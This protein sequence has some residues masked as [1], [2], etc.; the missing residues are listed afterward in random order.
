M[1]KMAVT[2]TE[3]LMVRALSLKNDLTRFTQ[4]VNLTLKSLDY[5]RYQSEMLHEHTV[6]LSP[7][8]CDRAF[9]E[10][11]PKLRKVST[12]VR[13]QDS[14]KEQWSSFRLSK[15]YSGN[16]GRP[17]FVIS[18]EQ[19]EYLIANGFNAVEIG[20]LLGVSLST[21]RRRMIEYS[22][23][24]SRLF[25][26]IT[27]ENLCELIQDIKKENP[28]SG[29]RIML[30][31]LRARVYRVTQPRVRQMMQKEDPEGTVI[32]WMTTVQRRTYSVSGP[33]ALWHIDGNH[34]LIRYEIKIHITTALCDLS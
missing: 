18:Q 28:R 2:V 30:G 20:R 1:L 29:C 4:A 14:E 31:H 19:L 32:R 15:Y 25:S 21:V 22:I 17:E 8:G 11:I 13:A 23:D 33:N 10:V 24:T 7:L 6:R 5:L 9:N 16:C 26:N 27:D 3:H 12:I 34:K